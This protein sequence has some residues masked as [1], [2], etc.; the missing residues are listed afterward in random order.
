LQSP[1][2]TKNKICKP[3]IQH[4]KATIQLHSRSKCCPLLRTCVLSLGYH[5]STVLS[6]STTLC[7]SSALTEMRRWLH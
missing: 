6:L 5:W 3:K 7:F 1:K 4:E 2:I